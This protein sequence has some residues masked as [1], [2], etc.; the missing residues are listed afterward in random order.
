[1][2]MNMLNSYYLKFTCFSLFKRYWMS[3]T[4][5]C[6]FL[7]FYLYLYLCLR[8]CCWLVYLNVDSCFFTLLWLKCT[9]SPSCYFVSLV[10][11]GA[12]TKTKKF[13]ISSPP[14]VGDVILLYIDFYF[15]T[16]F[17][18]RNRPHNKIHLIDWLKK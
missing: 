5:L 10:Q 16:C 12:D 18:L 3:D 7:L 2:D 8:K 14:D 9:F 1:M 4:L 15:L 11:E 17:F 6:L 13:V